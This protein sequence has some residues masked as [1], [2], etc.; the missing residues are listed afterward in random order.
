MNWYALLKTAAVWDVE[1]DGTYISE[2]RR[3]YELEYK[4]AL[5]RREDFQF[6]GDPRRRQSIITQ[7]ER[8][9]WDSINK[10]KEPLVKTFAKWLEGHA[11]NDPALWAKQLV[12]SYKEPLEEGDTSPEKVLVNLAATYY[13]YTQNDVLGHSQETAMRKAVSVLW[14]MLKEGF[15]DPQ[16]C[17]S[18]AALLDSLASERG[19]MLATDVEQG[20]VDL[21]NFNQSFGQNF[22]STEE[23]AEYARSLP[24]SYFAADIDN[25]QLFDAG[26]EGFAETLSQNGLF[27]GVLEDLYREF[28]FPHWYRYW[29]PQQIDQT[30][31]NVEAAYKALVE[32]KTLEENFKAVNMGVNAQHVN[33]GMFEYL[34]DYGG[35]KEV[36]E[37]VGPQLSGLTHGDMNPEWEQHLRDVGLNVNIDRSKVRPHQFDL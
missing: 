35:V 32:A 6:T 15:K 34:E 8:A 10:L 5:M 20:E 23:A 16:G 24:S 33:G 13:Q 36:G 4:F 19:E 9:L 11:I 2:V 17:P 30:R 21:D 29:Q 31:A 37:N 7:L 14:G 25:D 3:F 28:V 12:G 18:V 26:V 1:T 22:A 27:E